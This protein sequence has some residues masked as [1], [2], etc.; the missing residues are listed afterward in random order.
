MLN[1]RV[2]HKCKFA[3]EVIENFMKYD[4]DNKEYW[5]KKALWIGEVQEFELGRSA[6][7]AMNTGRNKMTTRVI[8]T[9][10]EIER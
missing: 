5:E 2:D 6:M 9:V 4:W 1:A 3:I 7:I 10:G 8:K